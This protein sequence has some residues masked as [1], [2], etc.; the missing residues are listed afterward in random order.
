LTEII[1]NHFFVGIV[2]LERGLSLA[3]HSTKL[4]LV[5]HG[6]LACAFPLVARTTSFRRLWEPP[7]PFRTLAALA[8]ESEDTDCRTLT[9]AEIIDVS[10]SDIA[11]LNIL[12]ASAAYRGNSHGAS[13]QDTREYF[14]LAL[15]TEGMVETIPLLLRDHATSYRASSCS[16]AHRSVCPARLRF[17]IRQ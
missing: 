12:L 5:N 10:P 11:S 9:K 7:P 13:R 6:A 4:Y 16:S 1:E 8:V 3:Q 17:S 15:N 2:D 14:S